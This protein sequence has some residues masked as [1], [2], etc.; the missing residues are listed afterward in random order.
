M[1]Q[2]V[3]FGEI[4]HEAN[5]SLTDLSPREWALVVPVVLF[6]VWIGVYPAAFTGPTEATIEALIGQVQSKASV[7]VDGPS[8]PLFAGLGAVTPPPVVLG[9]LLPTLIVA[10]TGMLVLLLDL[11]PPRRSKTHLRASRWPASSARCWR[12]C[13]PLGHRRPGVPRHDRARS[14]T[15]SSS[16]SSSPT[17]RRW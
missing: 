12:P 8:A 16:T 13:C 4:T 6:I 9:P 3:I 7:A 15:R 2:R 17:P 14:A 1:Y 11:V 10:G 5:R